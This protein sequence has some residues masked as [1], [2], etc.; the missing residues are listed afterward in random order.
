MSHA[1]ALAG[2]SV[3]PDLDGAGL[4]NLP[5]S[6]QDTREQLADPVLESTWQAAATLPAWQGP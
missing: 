4:H 1:G 3:Y 5:S 2:T 6:M